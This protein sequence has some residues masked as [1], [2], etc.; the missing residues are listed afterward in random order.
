[1]DYADGKRD[2]L[3]T[4]AKSSEFVLPLTINNIPHSS[5]LTYTYI[6]ITNPPLCFTVECTYLNSSNTHHLIYIILLPL[7][8]FIFSHQSITNHPWSSHYVL[9]RIKGGTDNYR[10]LIGSFIWQCNHL[11]VK[12]NEDLIVV[13]L[14]EIP[15]VSCYVSLI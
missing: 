4:S 13:V 2:S 8:R 11:T 3:S 10:V 15:L 7:H 6:I 9:Q 1:M 14:T 5:T 12:Y